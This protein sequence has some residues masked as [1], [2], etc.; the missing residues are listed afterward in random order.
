MIPKR[1]V[2]SVVKF[3][4][5]SILLILLLALQVTCCNKLTESDK[6]KL[7]ALE[8]KFGDRYSFEFTGDGLY[9]YAKLK[10]GAVMVSND[11]E[12]IFKIFMFIN[13]EK[14]IRRNNTFVY[15]NLY[16]EKGKFHHQL[17]YD[18]NENKLV[19]EYKVEH[20]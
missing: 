20:Y 19:R 2:L 18:P 13:Y 17:F 3:N 12:E 14:G 1:V 10:N 8:S 9:L 15:L 5:N 7:K 11:D 4:N 6:S 16:D